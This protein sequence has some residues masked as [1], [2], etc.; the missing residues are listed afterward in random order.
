VYAAFRPALSKT[1][2]NAYAR[3]A[4]AGSTTKI[5][6]PIGAL[7]AH[8]KPSDPIT[9]NKGTHVY[10]QKYAISVDNC[11]RCFVQKCFLVFPIRLVL[12][13]CKER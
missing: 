4:V 6:P 9:V 1:H 2:P 8:T 11:A 3:I 12:R 7:S 13:M 10:E 5:Q